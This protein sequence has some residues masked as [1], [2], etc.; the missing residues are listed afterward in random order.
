MA[1]KLARGGAVAGG[2]GV[3]VAAVVEAGRGVAAT[4]AAVAIYMSVSSQIS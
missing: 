1:V 2:A 4:A 3:A